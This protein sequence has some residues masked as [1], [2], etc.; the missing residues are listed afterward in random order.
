MKE[1]LLSLSLLS[2]SCFSLSYHLGIRKDAPLPQSGRV[3]HMTKAG[4]R[5]P[6]GGL[7]MLLLSARLASGAALWSHLGTNSLCSILGAWGGVPNSSFGP[8]PTPKCFPKVHIAV[9]NLA[10]CKALYNPGCFIFPTLAPAWD[11]GA[12]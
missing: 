7:V 4:P 12:S 11:L 5:S 8:S 3:A 1:A 6:V 2:L 10:T 9:L